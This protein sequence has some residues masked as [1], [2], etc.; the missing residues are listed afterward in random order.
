MP[1]LSIN[2]LWQRLDK[3]WVDTLYFFFGAETWLIQDYI[4]TLSQRLL[5]AAP[6]AF[7]CDIFQA[8]SDSWAEVLG[9]AQ[10]LPVMAPH[11]VVIVHDVHV[12][13]QTAWQQLSDY[14]AQPSAT[15]ALICSSHENEPRKVPAF[16]WQQA[17]AVACT[18][19]AGAALHEWAIERIT[20]SGYHITEEALAALFRDQEYDLQILQQ[21]IQKLCT[22]VGAS[23]EIGL[24][25]VH[26]VSL[27]SR[28]H[29]VFVLSEALL[30]SQLAQ[31]LFEVDQLLNQGEPPLVILSLII[32]HLRLLWSVKQLRQQ[33][34]ENT[35]I[36]KKLRLPLHVCRQLA[37][38]SQT[39]STARLQQLYT[40]AIEADLAFKSSNK[41]PKSILEEFILAICM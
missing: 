17:Q 40:V 18:N 24:E 12:L 25:A 11:R 21:E 10:T 35:Q 23:G 38:Q 41:S 13:G 19:L 36:A 22:Y 7:N 34:Q 32:R 5:G 4:A 29:S 2:A 16:F 27:A 15:T 9:S 33:R 3:G 26:Q 37:R 20:Q 39:L 1:R 30:S 31:A 8:E 28:I 14:L 6:R